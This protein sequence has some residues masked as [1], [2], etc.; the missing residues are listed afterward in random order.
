MVPGGRL[1]SSEYQLLVFLL[2]VQ[3]SNPKAEVFILSG[4]KDPSENLTKVMD[5]LRRH[6]NT[7]LQTIS[8]IVNVL[9]LIY[10]YH[11]NSYPRETSS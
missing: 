4:I 5:S 8:K 10:E 9:K 3:D 7:V 11:I 1:E 2:S 6:R